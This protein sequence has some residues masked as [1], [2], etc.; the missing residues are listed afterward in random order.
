MRVVRS[1][2]EIP[3]EKNAVVTVGTFDGVHLAHQEIIR[4]VVNRTRMRE[5]RSMVVTFEPHPKE[6]VR[7][8]GGPVQL[9]STMDERVAK[10]GTLQVDLLWII[11]FTYEFSRLSSQEFYRR[12]LVEGAGVSEVVVGYDHMFGRDREAGIEALIR[13]GKEFDFSVFAVHPYAVAGAPVSSTRVRKALEEGD[14]A[15][16]NGMLGY[17]YA[18]Q[19]IVVRGDGRGAT[20]GYPTANI[21]VASERKVIP[22]RGVYVVGARAGE[23][24]LYGMMNIGV[25]PTIAPG[26]DVSIEVHLLNFSGDLYGASLEISFLHRLREE[27]KFASVAELIHQLDKDRE[28]SLRVIA[29]RVEQP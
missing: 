7:P 29:A 22:A 12:Y 9:L 15:A 17:P 10:I 23:R 5:G 24:Q 25:R 18:M 26:N 27:R 21:R 28:E 16:A 2:E 19:G 6:V 3:R 1:L 11:H 4:E 13:M 20:I 8:H 14:I